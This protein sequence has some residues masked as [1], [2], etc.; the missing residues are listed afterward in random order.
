MQPSKHLAAVDDT[1]GVVLVCLAIAIDAVIQP[2]LQAVQA[3]AVH[4]RQSNQIKSNQMI[5]VI[6]A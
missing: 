5:V 3:I 1:N 4:G 6:C 2:E